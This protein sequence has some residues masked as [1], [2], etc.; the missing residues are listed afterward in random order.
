M[1]RFERICALVESSIGYFTP[2]AAA[3]ALDAYDQGE[4]RSASERCLA[5]YGGDLR[6]MVEADLAYWAVISEEQRKRTR[7][8]VRALMG[9]DFLTQM[10]ASLMW[11]TM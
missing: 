3:L 5:C 2:A 8:E 11:P 9:S 4:T 10:T 7:R 6:K 1:D